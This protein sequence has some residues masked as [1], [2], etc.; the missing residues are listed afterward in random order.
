MISGSP[1]TPY[2]PWTLDY[3]AKFGRLFSLCL[4][5]LL[6]LAVP[7]VSFAGGRGE[8]QESIGMERQEVDSGGP[9]VDEIGA[10]VLDLGANQPR[11]V[12][13]I[14]VVSIGEDADALSFAQAG[15]LELEN[16]ARNLGLPLNSLGFS[17]DNLG[18]V[19]PPFRS[20]IQ[21][22][23]SKSSDLQVARALGGEL[24]FRYIALVYAMV[25]DRRVVWR[26]GVFDTF[27]NQRMSSDASAGF[28]GLS[29][30]PLI[31]ESARRVARV[32]PSLDSLGFEQ[33][34]IDYSLVFLA[35]GPGVDVFLG[36][37]DAG[38]LLGSSSDVGEGDQESWIIQFDYFP[39]QAGQE[40]LL[41]A[42]LEGHYPR[43]F[44]VQIDLERPESPISIP[45]IQPM[46]TQT[47]YWG[48]GIPRLLGITGGMRIYINPDK[49][50]LG[51]ENTLWTS[52]AFLPGARPLIHNEARMVLGGHIFTQPQNRFRI[53][54]GIGVGTILTYIPSPNLE[55][56][57]FADLVLDPLMIG[58]EYHVNWGIL[59]AEIRKPFAVGTGLLEFGWMDPGNMGIMITLGGMARW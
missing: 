47:R 39:F 12:N 36:D 45:W 18:M 46:L 3:L 10:G 32:F 17:W 1:G 9:R 49:L 28:A 26:I 27:R 48:I 8:S 43:E 37:P 21:V 42:V 5:L 57:I 7:G 40:L 53:V 23:S 20:G 51:Y 30:L 2:Y 55:T 33:L 58:F 24:G 52:Y 13:Q 41:T 54:N 29:A 56:Q 15:G 25:E 38:V 16:Q 35:P 34:T 6:G 19:R 44:R 59:W 11:P 22:L 4:L 31:Q 50:F 14:L